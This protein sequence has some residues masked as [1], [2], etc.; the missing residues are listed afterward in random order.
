MTK[1]LIYIMFIWVRFVVENMKTYRSTN[2]ASGCS[3]NASLL[4]EVNSLMLTG[5]LGD[6]VVSDSDVD[7]EHILRKYEGKETAFMWKSVIRSN[8]TNQ[9]IHGRSIETD[10][11]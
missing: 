4:S 11:K 9:Q 1:H 7:N 10:K 5:K 3:K 2:P 6:G 8:L